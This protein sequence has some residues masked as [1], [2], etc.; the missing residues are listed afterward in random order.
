MTSENKNMSFLFICAVLFLMLLCFPVIVWLTNSFTDSISNSIIFFDKINYLKSFYLISGIYSFLLGI[1]LIFV[2][3]FIKNLISEKDKKHKNLLG[4][5][6]N[7]KIFSEKN[8]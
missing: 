4:E 8:N 2:F 7:I 6:E 5:I 1:A 3:L